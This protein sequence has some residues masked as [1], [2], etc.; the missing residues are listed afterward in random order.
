LNGVRGGKRSMHASAAA[1]A[2]A[3]A[4][5]VRMDSDMSI[6]TKI[7]GPAW[8]PVGNSAM[9]GEM[10]TMHAMVLRSWSTSA[11]NRGACGSSM[12]MRS[13]RSRLMA[14]TAVS[15]LS[16]SLTIHFVSLRLT[17]TQWLVQSTCRI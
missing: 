6:R 9:S 10:L 14:S 16:A 17:S 5:L 13:K 4:P 2:S 11:I 1:F 8:L 7:S 15:E 12:P 3:S